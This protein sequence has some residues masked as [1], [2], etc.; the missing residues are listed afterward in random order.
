MNGGCNCAQC[1]KNPSLHSH[2]FSLKE[3]RI[4]VKWAE[5]IPLFPSETLCYVVINLHKSDKAH[6][7]AALVLCGEN[8]M[9]RYYV[10][11]L[12][13]PPAPPHSQTKPSA[14]AFACRRQ[15]VS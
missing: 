14:H 13:T 8:P 1:A 5:Q 15:F 12:F 4:L 3:G 6:A 7:V 11:S 9:V 2:T 10:S